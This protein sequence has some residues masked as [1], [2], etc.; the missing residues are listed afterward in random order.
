MPMLSPTQ[1]QLINTLNISFRQ[2]VIT[3]GNIIGS[4][5]VTLILLLCLQETEESIFPILPVRQ[6]VMVATTS[7]PL[8]RFFP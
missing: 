2:M 4:S 6:R 8:V 7:G 1:N 3:R 5:T